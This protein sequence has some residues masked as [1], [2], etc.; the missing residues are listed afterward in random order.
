MSNVPELRLSPVFRAIIKKR[1]WVRAFFALLLVPAT[2]FALKVQQ[3]N[4]IDR[5][6]VQTDPD[7]IATQEFAKVFGS[8]E[9]AIVIAEAKDPFSVPV[10]TRV[11]EIETALAKIKKVAPT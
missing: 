4:G 7:Y 10:L 1:Y 8:A 6:I 2:Y 11:Q 9:Y 3:D 5:L